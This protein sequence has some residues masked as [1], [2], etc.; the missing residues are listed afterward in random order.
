MVKIPGHVWINLTTY[1]GFPPL[2]VPFKLNSTPISYSET[3]GQYR[4]DVDPLKVLGDK[5]DLK[6]ADYIWSDW[7]VLTESTSTTSFDEIYN[8]YRSLILNDL[9]ERHP[10]LLRVFSE[11][12]YFDNFEFA[13]GIAT[14]FMLNEGYEGDYLMKSSVEG[15]VGLSPKSSI[16]GQILYM[17]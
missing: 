9:N 5:I 14:E 7:E 2:E 1:L 11:T 15:V 8:Q 10:L 3:I 17:T 4:P 6:L 13:R 16:P 12:N